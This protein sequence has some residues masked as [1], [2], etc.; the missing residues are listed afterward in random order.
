MLG[1]FRLDT[2]IRQFSRPPNFV[3]KCNHDECKAHDQIATES[4]ETPC[5]KV[6]FLDV[7]GVLNY[8]GFKGLST[9]NLCPIRLKRLKFILDNVSNCKIVL[10]STWRLDSSLQKILFSEMTNHCKLKNIRNICIGQT[11]LLKETKKRSYEI[12]AWLEE[13]SN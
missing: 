1:C 7:D 2:N 9:N 11:P 4:G 8:R 3:M 13:K 12:A 5:I 10:S 6:L